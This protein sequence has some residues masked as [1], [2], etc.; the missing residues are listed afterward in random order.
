SP[1]HIA[2]FHSKL[3][4][5]SSWEI[6]KRS[7]LAPTP[8]RLFGCSLERDLR[9]YRGYI[10]RDVYRSSH[11]EATSRRA[12]SVGRRGVGGMCAVT[13]CAG[14]RGGFSGGGCDLMGLLILLLQIGGT[15]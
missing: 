13:V 10:K 9:I 12:V 4:R 14:R 1:V 15:V 3:R 6:S 8:A 7:F 2:V 5:S 11:F